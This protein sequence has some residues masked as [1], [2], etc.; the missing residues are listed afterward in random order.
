MITGP[1]LL[2][3]PADRPDRYEK[4]AAAGDSVILDLE[5]AVALSAKESARASLV[6]SRLDP[7]HVIVRV[8]PESTGLQARDVEALRRTEY[9]T[10]M[11]PKAETTADLARL[12]DFEV[13]A[14]CESPLGV[15]NA[16]LIVAAPHVAAL[17]WGAEDLV[18]ALG[19]SSSRFPDGSYREYAR[20]TRSHVLISAAS[21]GKAAFD[22][23]HLDIRDDDGQRSEALDAAASGFAGAMC[24]HPRQVAIIRSAFVPSSEKVEWARGVLAAAAAAGNGVFAYDGRMVDEPV[25]RQARRVLSQHQGD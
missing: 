11:L 16:S 12:T 25:L 19:G 22:T 15:R 1:A 10:V 14:I 5:D 6:A 7:A 9:R 4:A 21:E 24:I 8:N 3:C 13:I 2:F 18:A 23:V 17:T 20:Y